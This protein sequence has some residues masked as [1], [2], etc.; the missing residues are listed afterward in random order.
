MT[1]SPYPGAPFPMRRARA[2]WLVCAALLLIATAVPPIRAQD[3]GVKQLN[4][5]VLG[6]SQDTPLGGAIVYIENS[7]NNDIKSYITEN[8]GG[9]HFANLS[10]DT[11]Y[12]LWAAYKGKKSATKTVSS[13]DT[14]K[15]VF[16]DLHIKE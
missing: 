9:Y 10:A 4:G 16:I 13:F 1:R 15:Q 11:D 8:D 14:R 6:G 7:R 5:K 2:A 3:Y 12:T